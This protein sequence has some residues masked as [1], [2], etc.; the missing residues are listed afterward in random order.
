MSVFSVGAFNTNWIW[1]GLLNCSLSHTTVVPYI[2]L[3]GGG[4]G[5]GEGGGCVPCLIQQ[6]SHTS[7]WDCA[8]FTV[9]YNSCPIHPG[10]TVFCSL[11][12]TTAV[13]Y[14]RG[15]GGGGCVPCFIQQLSHTSGWDCVPCFIQQ[16]SHTS[17]W[18]CVLFPVSYNSCPIHPGGT[19]ELFPVSY[20]S[21][22]IHPGGAVFCSLSHTTVVPYIRVGLCSVPCLIQQLSHT[23][24]WDCVPCLIQQL[25]HTSGWDC[26]PCLIQQLSHTSGWDC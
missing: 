24:G 3:V 11:S 6:L 25:S 18:G 10:G 5:E 20:N 19:A 15:G 12:H 26:V 13:P 23:S 4:G 21:C 1:V 22:P 8:V 17:G 16:L 7:G 14:I 2:R 9:S